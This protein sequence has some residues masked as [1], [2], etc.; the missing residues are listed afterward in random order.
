MINL[1]QLKK[2]LTIEQ[3]V[4]ILN[5]LGSSVYQQHN[6]EIIF[7]SCCHHIDCMAHKPKLYYYI[8]THSFFCYSCSSAFDIYSLIQERWNLLNKEFTFTQ[9]L[10]YI[11]DLLGLNYTHFERVNPV[12]KSNVSWKQILG[13]YDRLS[14]VDA[15]LKIWDKSI[16]QLFDKWYPI[17]W[18]NEGISIETM[19]QFQIGYYNLYNQTVIPCFDE[20]NNLIGIRVRNWE[21]EKVKQSKYNS[22]ITVTNY[23]EKNTEKGT[24]FKFSTNSVLYGLNFNK[25]AIESEKV[26]ILTESEKSVLKSATWYGHRSVTLGMFGNHLNEKRK[27]MILNYQPNEI[28]IAPDYD[29]FD[30][31]S[32]EKWAR[33]QE[34]FGRMF[35][36]YCKV[37]IILNQDNIIP[38]KNNAFDGTKEEFEHLY[39][40]RSDIFE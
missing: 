27:Q 9:I 26:V 37:T 14:S 7:Y 29:Y 1:K 25:Y 22:L 6:T 13:K 31:Q 35:K 20:G 34:K 10:Q 39:K 30:D 40:Q 8:D 23:T 17:E 4:I 19:R 28:V 16:L 15:Q 3:I 33:K 11:I 36:N 32:Y 24:D 5:D 12:F 21:P 2:E 38:F 18:I